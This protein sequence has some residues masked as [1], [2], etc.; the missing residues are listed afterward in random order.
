MRVTTVLVV[1]AALFVASSCAASYEPLAGVF[2][3]WMRQHG[4]SYSNEEFVFRWNV[5]KENMKLIEEHN[6]S[7]KTFFL[8][9]N[10]FGDLTNAEFNRLYKGLKYDH[11]ARLQK[12][13]H[14]APE[15]VRA[16]VP[17]SWDWRQKGAVTQVKNQGTL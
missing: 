12:V 9:M 3:S 11:S 16:G 7:N 4:K 8:A 6:K 1:L 10:K 13:G 5:W 17:S 14:L 15:E 2:A